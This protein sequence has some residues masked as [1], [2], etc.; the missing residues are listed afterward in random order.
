VFKIKAK[1][2]RLAKDGFLMQTKN[3]PTL[4]KTLLLLI[5]IAGITQTSNQPGATL[6]KADVNV[7]VT[8][9]KNVPRENEQIIF[10]SKKNG[11]K[12][13]GRS[14]KEGKFSLQLP[15]GDTF[16]IK[17][18]TIVD[19]TKYGLIAIRQLEEDEHFT[20]PFTV[21][22]KFEPK[23][24]YTLDNVH[25]DFGNASLRPDS[26]AEL[27]EL[28]SYMQWKKDEKIEIAGHTDN[29]G[30]DADNMKLSR[31]RAESI[32]QFLVKKGIESTRIIAKGYGASIP[33][34]DNNTDEG[35]Q[36]NRRTEVKIL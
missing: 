6:E 5:P 10:I 13:S 30:N 20:E 12:F 29:V 2:L 24:S 14:G 25:F 11:L 9:L 34:A 35:R 36:K 28:L 32:K 1:Y 26:F 3:Y 7:I 21:T 16:V 4:F 23:R 18:K 8:N 27:N 15:I 31:Q 22:V 17:V 19:S 33:V